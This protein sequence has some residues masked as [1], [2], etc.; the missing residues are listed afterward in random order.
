[1]E[2][3]DNLQETPSK[4]NPSGRTMTDGPASVTVFWSY[5]AACQAPPPTSLILYQRKNLEDIRR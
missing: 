3:W 5:V 1:V 4:P 2:H